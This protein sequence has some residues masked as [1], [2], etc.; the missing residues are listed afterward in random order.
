MSEHKYC[1]LV[2]KKRRSC[3][4]TTQKKDNSDEC[5]FKNNKCYTLVPPKNKKNSS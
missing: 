2:K 3:K 1:L 4:V 5:V